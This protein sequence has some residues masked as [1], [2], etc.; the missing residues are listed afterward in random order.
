M[1]KHE[2]FWWSLGDFFMTTFTGLEWVYENMSPN[3]ILIVVGFVAT[4]SWVYVQS[5]YNTKFEKEGGLK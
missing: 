1:I 2:G 4:A 3:K 5:K